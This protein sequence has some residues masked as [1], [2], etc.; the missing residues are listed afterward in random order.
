MIKG[1]VNLIL[2]SKDPNFPSLK[3]IMHIP[4][5]WNLADLSIFS[6]KDPKNM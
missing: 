2:F 4:Q 3:P 1:D 6:K 5:G